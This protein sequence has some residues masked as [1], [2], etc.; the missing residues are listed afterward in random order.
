MR[1]EEFGAYARDLREARWITQ[2][3][4]TDKTGMAGGTVSK[5]EKSERPSL[6]F[7]DTAVTAYD[8][9]IELLGNG[10]I[11]VTEKS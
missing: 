1:I 4:V 7:M 10:R 5:W 8:L 3:D 6:H 2:Q 11:E 9:R